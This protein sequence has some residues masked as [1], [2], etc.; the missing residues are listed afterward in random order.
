MSNI[1]IRVLF[2]ISV[3][4]MGHYMPAAAPVFSV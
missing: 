3:L 4:G 2:D 1:P